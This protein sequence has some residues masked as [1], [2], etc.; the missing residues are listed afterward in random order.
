MGEQ[1]NKIKLAVALAAMSFVA[2]KLAA[3]TMLEEAWTGIKQG[4]TSGAFAS[5]ASASF[6]QTQESEKRHYQ[7]I[8]SRLREESEQIIR[9]IR[10]A[11]KLPEGKVK[12]G[13]L[14]SDRS[15][16]AELKEQI[17]NLEAWYNHLPAK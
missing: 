11:E 14:D 3:E 13:R 8:L 9:S 12:R 16:L 2:E 7:E 4:S 5:G 15:W 10:A 1:M 6:G 17:R